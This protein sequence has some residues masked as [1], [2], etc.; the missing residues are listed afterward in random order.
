M[1]SKICTQCKIEKHINKFNKKY[2]E[3]KDCLIKRRVA[4]YYD[5]IDKISFQQKI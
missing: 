1:E 2:S 4:R 5:N 3:C